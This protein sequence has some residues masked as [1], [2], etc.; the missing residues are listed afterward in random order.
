MKIGIIVILMISLM[1]LV[2]AEGCCTSLLDT[3]VCD[4]TEV[5]QG[6][7]TGN[8]AF[9]LRYDAESEKYVFIK[10]VEDG[11]EFLTIAETKLFANTLENLTVLTNSDERVTLDFKTGILYFNGVEKN[12]TGFLTRYGVKIDTNGDIDIPFKAY[13]PILEI[14]IKDNKTKLPIKYGDKINLNYT[15]ENTDVLKETTFIYNNNSNKA[16]EDLSFEG[17]TIDS[18]SYTSNAPKLV[19][20]AEKVT[21]HL[22]FSEVDISEVSS[23]KPFGFKLLNA[24]AEIYEIV[25]QTLIGFNKK[26]EF[27]NNGDSYDDVW[28]WILFVFPQRLILGFSATDITSPGGCVE[29]PV[30]FA[31]V[32]PRELRDE[33]ITELSVELRN[34]T[35]ENNTLSMIEVY[36]EK[37]IFANTTQETKR[38]FIADKQAYKTFILSKTSRQEEA[39]ENIT[40]ENITT[41]K[42][43]DGKFS[44][45]T[46]KSY[47][48]VFIILFLIILVI[49]IVRY[50][51]A[52]KPGK[53]QL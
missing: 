45:R 35:F 16:F 52:K 2:A 8:E 39:M 49:V 40:T 12:V 14:K 33:N 42:P 18:G 20:H 36:S 34:V 47:A 44:G 53:N 38:I 13:E 31:K 17:L 11:S 4:G 6:P 1:Q 15:P 25:P 29:L 7:C 41:E 30:D 28:N 22:R 10:S 26:I 48:Y 24:N 27:L 5:H 9:I 51:R 43:A 19:V 46:V 3:G 23:S 50:S 32:C 21:Y 37:P